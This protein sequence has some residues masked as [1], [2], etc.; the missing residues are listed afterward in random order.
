MN[1]VPVNNKDFYEEF[2]KLV[3]KMQK[4]FE[5]NDINI[6]TDD[7]AG[8][9]HHEIALIAAWECFHKN[10]KLS[11]MIDDTKKTMSEISNKYMPEV[12]HVKA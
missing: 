7:P 11:S 4:Y 6:G 1:N 10:E 2:H 12:F 5:D 8:M 9:S 3:C